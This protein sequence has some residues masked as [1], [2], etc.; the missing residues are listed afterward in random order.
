LSTA[1]SAP[2]KAKTQ[3]FNDFLVFACVALASLSSGA[4][5]NGFGWEMVNYGILPFI[6]SALAVTFWLR[7]KRPALAA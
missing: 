7:L 2:E 5:Q 1:H 4:I 3:G 6:L